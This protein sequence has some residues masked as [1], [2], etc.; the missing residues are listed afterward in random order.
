MATMEGLE[1]LEY[2]L[3]ALTALTGLIVLFVFQYFR[4]RCPSCKRAW[5]LGT[6]R[7]QP[8]TGQTDMEEWECRHCGHR[9]WRGVFLG[10]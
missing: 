3:Y 1:K 6:T 10:G 4:R 2:T 8:Y 9:V 5:A 7:T